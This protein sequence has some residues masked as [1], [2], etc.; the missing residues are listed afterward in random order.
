M[1]CGACTMCYMRI[2]ESQFAD[3]ITLYARTREVLEQSAGEFVRTAAEWGFTVNLEKTKIL[4]IGRNLTTEDSIP[5]QLKKE[6]IVTFGEF[7]YLGS[8]ITR[9]GEVHGEVVA[10]L[11]IASRLLDVCVQQS[12][13]TISS[14]LPPRGS[15][16]SLCLALRG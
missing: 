4:P 7:T 13:R 15:Y 10:G 2:T 16:G 3:D 14:L 5:V 11:G 9:D 12:F 6:E 8:T 1:S